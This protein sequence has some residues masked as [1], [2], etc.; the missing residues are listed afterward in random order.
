[1]NRLVRSPRAPAGPVLLQDGPALNRRVE[2]GLVVTLLTL[3]FLIGLHTAWSKSVTHDEIWH[4]PV[5]ARNLRDGRF[6]I[7]RVNPPLSRMWAAVPLVVSGVHVD[8]ETVGQG[9][10]LKFVE[11]HP[12]D[13]GRWYRWG[14]GLNLAWTIATGCIVYLWGR[15]FYGPVSGLLSLLLYVTCPNVIAYGSV[16][17]PDAAGTF[18]FVS[19]LFAFT[20]WCERPRWRQAMLWGGML[21]IAQGA[22]FTCLILYPLLVVIAFLQWGKLSSE[23]R[24]SWKRFVPQVLGAVLVSLLVLCGSYGFQGMFIRLADYQFH[25]AGM[26]AIQALFSFVKWLPVPFPQ[27]YVLGIDEQRL[28]MAG[29]HPVYLDG[30]WSLTGFRTYFLK[31]LLYKLPHVF[32]LLVILAAYLLVRRRGDIPQPWRKATTLLC[33]VVLL[34][35]ITSYESLQLGL[36]YILP[37]LPLLMIFAGS[38]AHLFRFESSGRRR[39]AIASVTILCGLSLRFHPSHLT[40]FNE[41]AGGPVGGR[42]HLIDSNLDWGQDLNALSEYLKEQGIDSLGLAYFGMVPPKAMGIHY[43]LPPSWEPKPGLYAVSVNFVMGRPH[44][45]TLEDGAFRAADFQEFGYFRFFTPM[46]SF[47]GSIDLYDIETDDI[48]EWN[49]ALQASGLSGRRR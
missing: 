35:V 32:Q 39:L 43:E 20:L 11:D 45:I 41:G 29:Q 42:H 3:Q 26:Q 21:G 19:T 36:R 46:K 4:L 12:Q 16:V 37:V 47:G 1:M 7:E 10:G 18:G 28:V 23:F 49:Q 40:Y 2:I 17:T 5:G 9:L 34:I 6:D 38:S 14:R 31:A 25:S 8:R 27:D 30:D 22:K 15:R 44:G 33:P 24:T 48:E 13:F